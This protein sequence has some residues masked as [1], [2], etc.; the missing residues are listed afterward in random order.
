MKRVLITGSSGLIGSEA[1]ENYDRKGLEVH[2][3]DNNMRREFFGSKGDTLWN[4]ARL[5]HITRNFTHH[6][7]DIRDRKGVF[8]LFEQYKFDLIIHC[9]AQPS[10]DRTGTTQIDSHYFFSLGWAMRRILINRPSVHVDIGSHNISMNLLSAVVPVVFL[11]YRPLQLRLSGLNGIFGNILELPFATSS[12]ESV[13]C[14][15]VAEHIG[16]G[17]YG[18]PL[19][20][21]GT[22]KSSGRIGQNFKAWRQLIFCRAD[23]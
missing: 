18:D 3:V 20:S 10:H 1:A 9:A 7:L 14:L 2:G 17:R 5:K 19:N 12:I 21:R 11:D 15:H 8:E 6:N 22:K 23:W 13:S 4:L 16:L